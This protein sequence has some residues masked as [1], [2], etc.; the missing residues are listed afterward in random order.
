[1]DLLIISGFLGSGKTTLLRHLASEF[2]LTYP[3]HKI[4]IIENEVG[5][6]G[7]DGAFLKSENL[8]VREINSGCICCSP[9]AKAANAII[10]RL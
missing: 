9:R 1:M 2:E 6:V 10:G 5:K 3:S 7:V 4:A 8:L